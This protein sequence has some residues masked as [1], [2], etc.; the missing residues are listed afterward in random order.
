MLAE[1]IRPIEAL[2]TL[3]ARESLLPAVRLQVALQLVGAREPLAA[4]QPVTDERP[5]TRVPS[6]VRLEVRR[7]DVYLTYIVVSNA[8]FY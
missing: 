5:L 1:M 2:I 3:R 7:L 6:Q 4:E 8:G